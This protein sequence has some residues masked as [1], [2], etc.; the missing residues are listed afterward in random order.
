MKVSLRKANA[1][2]ESLAEIIKSAP[3]SDSEVDVLNHE[4][5]F[6]EINNAQSRYFDEI[7]N[8]LKLETKKSTPLI[9][10]T[11]AKNSM[12]GTPSGMSKRARNPVKDGKD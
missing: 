3:K 4:M 12:T 5:W 10:F 9:L 8:K 2:Q 7:R 6:E 1:L 11:R